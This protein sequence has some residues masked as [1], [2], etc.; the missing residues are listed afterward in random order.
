M[1]QQQD[2]KQNRGPKPTSNHQQRLENIVRQTTVEARVRRHT[3]SFIY[4]GPSSVKMMTTV[5]NRL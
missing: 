3:R 2:K 5:M 4:L 1:S